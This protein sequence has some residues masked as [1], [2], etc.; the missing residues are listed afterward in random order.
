M[1]VEGLGL[2]VRGRGLR[3]RANGLGCMVWGQA[4]LA[5]AFFLRGRHSPAWGRRLPLLAGHLTSLPYLTSLPR[6][7]EHR[8]VAAEQGKPGLGVGVW[9]SEL[10]VYGLRLG[11]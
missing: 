5:R 7:E 3:Q 1:R 4:P 2:R 9:D 8:V 6:T 11:I 10:R